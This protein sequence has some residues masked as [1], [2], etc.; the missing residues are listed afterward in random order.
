MLWLIGSW[1]VA[2]EPELAACPD[3][4][5]LVVVD[6]S[7]QVLDAYDRAGWIGAQGRGHGLG[8]GVGLS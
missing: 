6:S 2:Q 8:A 1:A 3:E 5:L 7:N 4:P